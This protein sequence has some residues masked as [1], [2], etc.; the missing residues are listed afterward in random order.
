MRIPRLRSVRAPQNG[1]AQPAIGLVKLDLGCGNNP[2]EGFIGVDAIKFEKVSVVHD[3]RQ[4]WPW[5]DSSV[6]EVHCSHFLEHLTQD[7]RCFF[8]N[9]LWRVLKPEAKALIITPHW[10]NNRAYGDPTHKWPA[11]TEMSY[12][13]LSRDWRAGNDKGAVAQAPHTDIAHNPNGLKCDLLFSAGASFGQDVSVKAQEV[14]IFET[15][16]YINK[17][18]DLHATVTAKK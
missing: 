6:D 2:R 7:E 4:P 17:A 5:T 1:H 11:V 9:E 14:Q 15:T 3:L 12:Y 18:I 16:H 8:F 13:Y 10:S